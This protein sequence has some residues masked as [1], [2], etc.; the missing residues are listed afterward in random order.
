MGSLWKLTRPIAIIA[1]VATIGGSGFRIDQAET[2][3][4]IN[5]LRA[6]RRKTGPRYRRGFAKSNTVFDLCRESRRRTP[7]ARWLLLGET[8]R[9]G[10]R[11]AIAPD[12]PFESTAKP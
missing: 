6:I 8:P 12:R 7:G 1:A 2:L 4:A 10:R 9:A 11:L 5:I 3:S